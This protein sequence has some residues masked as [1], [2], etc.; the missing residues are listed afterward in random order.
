M[1]FFDYFSDVWQR[2]FRRSKHWSSPI[3]DDQL[4]EGTLRPQSQNTTEYEILDE[5]FGI[6]VNTRPKRQPAAHKRIR[7][8][9]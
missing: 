9:A 5:C 4:T 8:S 6:Q 1:R 2:T 7:K 3:F